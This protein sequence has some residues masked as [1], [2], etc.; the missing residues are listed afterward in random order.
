MPG[1]GHGGREAH[2]PA[3]TPYSLISAL[4]LPSLGLD[5]RRPDVL[6]CSSEKK[7]SVKESGLV[8]RSGRG[9]GQESTR[10]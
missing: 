9:E 2:G 4:K 7:M 3:C 6:E 5:T 8:G 10:P 1:S